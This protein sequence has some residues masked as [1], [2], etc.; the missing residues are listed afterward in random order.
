VIMSPADRTY[1]DMKYDPDFGLGLDWAGCVELDRAY[2]WD[3]ADRLPGVPERALLGVEAALWSETLR[4]LADAQTMTFPRLPA[5]AE[6]GWSPRSAR[7]WQSFR[8]R[9][10]A[11]APRWQEAGIAYYRSPTV[12]WR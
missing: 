6:I 4:S 3:P 9:I 10:A 12:D 7:D 1:L 11:Y 2:D 5:I 8:R